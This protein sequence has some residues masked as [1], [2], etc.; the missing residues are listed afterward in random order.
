MPPRLSKLYP[1]PRTGT[2]LPP[3]FTLRTLGL[4][5][6]SALGASLCAV[7]GWSGPAWAL[8][9]VSAVTF[10]QLLAPA[11]RQRSLSGDGWLAE[12]G[13]AAPFLLFFAPY[14]A[15]CV[16][17]PPSFRP[18]P[19]W[20]VVAIAGAVALRLTELSRLRLGF[21]RELLEL[22]PPLRRSTL[23]LRSYQT[24][25]A[26]VGQELFYRG[27]LFVLLAPVL[28]WGVVPVSAALFVGEHWSNRW[29]ATMFTTPYLVRISALAL[30]LGVIAYAS[31]SVVPAIV[32]HVA[33][34]LAPV[35]QGLRH[36]R[37]NPYIPII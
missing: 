12:V 6:G 25:A 37:V 5:V 4:P 21:D 15:W 8:A 32:G 18:A 13:F 33:Y 19:V 28:G 24:M 34:N 35:M 7:L 27:A 11:I 26:A 23:L 2:E 20:I 17:F 9:G 10:V 3:I 36:R 1:A 22:M 30:G 29:A 16:M 31:G 14:V